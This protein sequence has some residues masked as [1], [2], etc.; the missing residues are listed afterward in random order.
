MHK[1]LNVGIH[2]LIVQQ[3]CMMDAPNV[4]VTKEESMVLLL[5]GLASAMK[6]ILISIKIF[7][8]PVLNA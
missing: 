2:V 3:L 5:T 1:L 4:S 6:V 7:R 8:I